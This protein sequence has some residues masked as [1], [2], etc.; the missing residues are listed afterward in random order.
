MKHPQ[1]LARMLGAMQMSEQGDGLEIDHFIDNF[2]WTGGAD[3]REC[4]REPM[5]PQL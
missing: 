3:F 4:R 2:D 5:A 1:R